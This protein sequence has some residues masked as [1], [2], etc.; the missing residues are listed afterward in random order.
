LVAGLV[1]L[2]VTGVWWVITKKKSVARPYSFHALLASGLGLVV[3]AV[4]VS[5]CI[6]DRP[7]W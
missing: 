2:C 7:L 3:L 1:S 5:E 4:F 6:P